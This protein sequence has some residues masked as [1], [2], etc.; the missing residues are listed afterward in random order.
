M[1]GRAPRTPGPKLREW[2]PRLPPQRNDIEGDE[3]YLNKSDILT[4]ILLNIIIAVRVPLVCGH[5]LRC[6]RAQL[7]ISEKDV[8]KVI[9]NI[10]SVFTDRYN[11]LLLICCCYSPRVRCV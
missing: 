11:I 1:E 2:R 9:P 3:N 4:L 7:N 10:A 6:Q 5:I 8:T